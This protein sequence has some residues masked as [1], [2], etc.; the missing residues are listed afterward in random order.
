MILK[1]WDELPEA[2]RTDA[3]RPYYDALSKRKGALIAKR[4]F[5]I[6]VSAILLVALWPSRWTP[7]AL[8]FFVRPA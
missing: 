4:L 3:V 1:P 6:V 7:R 8:S 5:D 2:F